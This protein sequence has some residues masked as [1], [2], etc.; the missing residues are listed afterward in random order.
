[1]V[2]LLPDLL[3]HLQRNWISIILQGINGINIYM[4]L[5]LLWILGIF[6]LSNHEETKVFLKLAY[7]LNSLTLSLPSAAIVYAFETITDHDQTCTDVQTDLD[8]DCS[9]FN[10]YSSQL[11]HLHLYDKSSAQLKK[12]TTPTFRSVVR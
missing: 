1:M 7:F 5:R 3:I 10:Q 2:N 9:L 11:H 8:P 6:Y 12:W 4:F